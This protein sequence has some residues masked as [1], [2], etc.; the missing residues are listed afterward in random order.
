MR[1]PRGAWLAASVILASCGTS[2]VD[3]GDS[4]VAQTSTT[5]SVTTTVAS[6]TAPVSTVPVS[7]TTTAPSASS[8]TSSTS[9]STSTSSTTST[10]TTIPPSGLVLDA[11]GVPVNGQTSGVLI[12]PTGW[13][14]PI[15]DRTDDGWTV[16]TPCGRAA[17]LA[18]GSLIE[19]ADIVLDPG[20]GG[21]SEPGA[22]GHGGLREADLNLE[23]ALRVRDRLV[24]A[25]YSVVMTRQTDVRLP[26]VTRGE[27]AQ[28]LDPIAFI[29]IHHNAG[30]D[31]P[32]AEPGT[33]MFHQIESAESRRL[34][35][36][37]YEETFAVLDAYDVSWVSLGDA[38]ALSRPNRAGTDYYGVLRRPGPVTSVLA[39]FAYISNAS[40][41]QL[42][43]QVA[44]QEELAGAVLRAVDRLVGTDDPG[45]GFSVDPIF[46]GYGPSGAGRTD[47]CTD[48]RLQ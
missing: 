18:D 31:E 9:T 40:E 11:E 3:L 36:L 43:S 4:A 28:A 21:S 2:S 16:W 20:H 27:I 46:R 41:E 14:T 22:V 13:I 10:T 1:I 45:S 35:G 29:S 8:T 39:E 23:V 6:T 5:A 37:L 24:G 17:E 26:I 44:V 15:L 19:S 48:P 12:T 38:G 30:T 32:S 33:E 34:A 47:D 7:T 25:G 42:L